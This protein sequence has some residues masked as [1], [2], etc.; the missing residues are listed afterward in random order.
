MALFARHPLLGI[1]LDN[2]RLSYGP[3]LGRPRF[4][5]RLNTHNMY[6]EFLVGGGVV[7][8]LAFLWTIVSV[9]G[10]TRPA[11]SGPGDARQ[12]ALVG[13]AAALITFALHGLVD[14]FIL[15]TPIYVVTALTIGLITAKMSS[16]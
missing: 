3:V 5:T 11:A 12:W 16:H 13:A 15:F 10:A 14:C 2:F 6:L 4:D 9:A 1:G 8:G 7:G